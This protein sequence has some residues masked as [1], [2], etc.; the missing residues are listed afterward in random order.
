M[1]KD[2][3]GPADIKHL[4]NEF[5]D[6]A[7]T[8]EVIGFFF[9]KVIDVDWD[10]HLPAMCAFWE[11]VIF[12]TGNYQGN[13]METHRHVHN[14]YTTTPAHFN[15]W[16]NLFT[17]TVDDLFE[18]ENAELVKQRAIGIANVMLSKISG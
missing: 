12:S 1:K 8:D 10:T 15:R 17:G 11:N 2:I 9:D 6:K 14:L 18:G 5:Y 3:N 13:P 4:V 7:R 16:L